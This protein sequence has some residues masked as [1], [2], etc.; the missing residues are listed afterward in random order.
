MLTTVNNSR[1]NDTFRYRR[2]HDTDTI[3]SWQCA[4]FLWMCTNFCR[5]CATLQLLGTLPIMA[6]KLCVCRHFDIILHMFVQ[7]ANEC[8]TQIVR[9]LQQKLPGLPG[10]SYAGESASFIAQYFGQSSF[11]FFVFK[12]FQL[13]NFTN[14]FFEVSALRLSQCNLYNPIVPRADICQ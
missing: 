1:K 14:E 8:W 10:Q 4:I 7:D 13:I 12:F 2:Q 6:H 9:L 3:C 5:K 11:N